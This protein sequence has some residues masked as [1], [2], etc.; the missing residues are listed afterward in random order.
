MN[1]VLVRIQK[2]NNNDKRR[3]PTFLLT[4]IVKEFK[5][6]VEQGRVITK[7]NIIKR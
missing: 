6:S 7:L 2:N 4:P 1:L 5:S 3:F